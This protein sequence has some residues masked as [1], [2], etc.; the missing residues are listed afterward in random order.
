MSA[1]MQPMEPPTWMLD[2]F[3]A[4][5]AL[6]ISSSSG[7]S[8]FAD[9][10]EMQFGTK[11]VHGLE[12]VKKFFVELDA[13]FV[14]KHMVDGVWQIGSAVF[15]QGSADLRKKGDPN[16]KTIHAAPLFNL[17]WLNDKGKVVRYVVDF[18]PDAA[19]AAGVS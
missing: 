10:I 8:V 2:L 16:A 18:P 1:L 7:F 9:D 5:D 19:K 15:M 3:K 14:T 13:P 12:A 17:I 11:S 6:D 4:I